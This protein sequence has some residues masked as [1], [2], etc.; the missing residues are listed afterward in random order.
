VVVNGYG[1]AS[2]APGSLVELWSRVLPADEVVTGWSGGSFAGDADEW[3]VTLTVP[4]SAATIT[5]AIQAVPVTFLT[6]TYTAPTGVA[7]IAR[8]YAPASPRGIIL[9]LHGTGGTSSFIE[10][11]ES[12]YLALLAISRGYA[13]LSPEAEEAKAGDLDGDGKE[14]WNVVLAANNIDLQAL[15][16]LI[17]SLT[18]G[19]Q[20]PANVP[21][22]VLGMSRRRDGGRPGRSRQFIGRGKFPP[23]ALQGGDFLLRAGPGRCDQCDADANG[24]VSVRQ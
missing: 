18:A 21:L 1:P 7:K 3:H 6:Q 17:A 23:V 13:V 24:L 2:A 14:R 9:I 11:T 10:R 16:Q 22:Y 15:N 19:G 4:A 12:R 8:F 20:L 5:A